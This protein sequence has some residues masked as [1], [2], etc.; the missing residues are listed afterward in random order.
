MSEAIKCECGVDLLPAAMF[1]HRCGKKLPMAKSGHEI[2]MEMNRLNEFAK[3]EGT[4]FQAS[5]LA[6]TLRSALAWSIGD[7]PGS[8]ADQVIK[9][10]EMHQAIMETIKKFQKPKS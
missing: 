6:M 2:K 7:V 3:R 5:L 1:C 8:L 10:D 4:D 9:H